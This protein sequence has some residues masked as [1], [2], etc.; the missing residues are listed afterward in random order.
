MA[1]EVLRVLARRADLLSALRNRQHTKPELA[2]TL[3]VSRSTVDRA[4]RNL[5]SHGLVERGDAVSLTLTGA[6]ALDV[7]ERFADRVATLDEAAPLLNSLPTDATVDFPLLRNAAVVNPTRVAPQRAVETYRSLVAD[8]TRVR[9]FASAVL[10]S[11]IS[12]FRE[13]IV[14]QDVPVELVLAP[15]A[16]DVL[17][18]SHDDAIAESR[19]SGNLVLYRATTTL[20]YSLMLVEHGAVTHVCGLFYDDTGRIGLVRNDDSDAVAWAA[21]VYESLRADAEPLPG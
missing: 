1:V 11:N 8:A 6:L 5:E 9:G 3:S 2:E 13:R 7:Y 18:T 4:I 17:V 15:E 16:L 14:E 20:D 19:A 21:D 10:D 12:T